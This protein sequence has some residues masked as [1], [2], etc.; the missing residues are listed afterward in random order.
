MN[1]DD[2]SHEKQDGKMDYY[3]GKDGHRPW[4]IIEAFDLNFN[5]GNVIKYVCRAGRK[6]K[7][8]IEDL[9]KARVYIEREINRLS[10][11]S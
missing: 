1:H 8:P 3:E 10:Q 7:N 11:R 4:D 2:L 5:L 6:T 9:E